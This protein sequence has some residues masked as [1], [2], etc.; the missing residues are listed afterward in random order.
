MRRMRSSPNPKVEKHVV[1]IYLDRFSIWNSP[2][3]GTTK[4]T[5]AILSQFYCERLGQCILYQPPAYFSVFLGAIR[6]F[7]DPVT[8]GKLVIRKGSCDPGTANDE[9]LQLLLG[10]NWREITGVG[11]TPVASGVS[12]GYDHSRD[13]P[14]LVAEEAITTASTVTDSVVEM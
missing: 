11:M 6:P 8:Y 14:A 13:W 10:E 7:I 1:F 3:M 9:K 12:P 4:R 5:I 2:A